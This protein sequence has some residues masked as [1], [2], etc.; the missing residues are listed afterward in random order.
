MIKTKLCVAVFVVAFLGGASCRIYTKCGLL[1]ELEKMQFPR[2]YARQCKARC[3]FRMQCA[4]TNGE[5]TGDAGSFGANFRTFSGIQL[6]NLTFEQK[7]SAG[8]KMFHVHKNNYRGP[9][10]SGQ[11]FFKKLFAKFWRSRYKN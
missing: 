2:S 4:K 3:V 10:R 1:E 9:V 8:F 5:G 11:Q 7:F 6:Q